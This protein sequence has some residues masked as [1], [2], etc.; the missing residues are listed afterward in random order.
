MI[1]AVALLAIV[2]VAGWTRTPTA[3]PI[4]TTGLNQPAGVYGQGQTL[5]Q[6]NAG[7]VQPADCAEPLA[8]R[9][10]G[11][12]PDQ[13]QPVETRYVSSSRPRVIRYLNNPENEVVVDGGR[14]VAVRKRG[15]STGKSVA[16][17]GGSA[18]AGAAIGA[19]AGGGKGA[20][21]GAVTGGTAGFIYDRLT[22]N[23]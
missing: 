14:E 5:P 12:A 11:Y 18:G 8:I 16:I 15:R 20:A 22:H 9:Q 2:A 13:L 1:A 19:L 21:L 4:A 7:Y 3:S 6:Q 10:A 23:R 17:V